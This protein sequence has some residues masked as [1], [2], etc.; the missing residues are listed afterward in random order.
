MEVRGMSVLVKFLAAFAVG[1]IL[2]LILSFT[3]YRQSYYYKKAMA[4][5]NGGVEEPGKRSRLV[6]VAILLAMILFFVL[7]DL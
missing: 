7:F 1:A 3:V 6:T 2:M 4:E 5:V